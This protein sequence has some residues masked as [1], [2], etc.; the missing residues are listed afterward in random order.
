MIEF[1]NGF[2]FL[3]CELVISYTESVPLDLIG[4]IGCPIVFVAKIS[5]VSWSSG[6]FSEVGLQLTDNSV[7]GYL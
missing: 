4:F 7:V 1:R 2:S 6:C 3:F 5:V